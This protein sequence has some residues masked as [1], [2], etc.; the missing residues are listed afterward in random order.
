M[1][2]INP[3]RVAAK[4]NFS[5]TE[6]QDAQTGERVWFLQAMSMSG[7]LDAFVAGLVEQYPHEFQTKAMIAAGAPA[8]GGCYS[9]DQC[10]AVWKGFSDRIDAFLQM[11]AR[12][13]MQEGCAPDAASQFSFQDFTLYY[14]A[15]DQTAADFEGADAQGAAL[16]SAFKR[17][18]YS[19]LCE[20][21]ARIAKKDLPRLL[22][23]FC[24]ESHVNKLAPVYCPNLSALLDEAIK[25]HAER[26]KALLVQTVVTRTVFREL[27]FSCSEGVPVPFVG[28]SRFG[29]TKSVAGWCAAHPGRARLV[30]VPDSNREIDFIR[31]H[32]DAFGIAYTTTISAGAL[33]DKVESVLRNSGLMVVYDEAHFLIPV[34][35]SKATAPRRLNWVRSQVIDQGVPCAFFA[36]P[37]SYKQ[38]LDKYVTTTGYR[39]EQWLGRMAPPVIL[40]DV[41]PFEEIVAV[42]RKHFPELPEVLLGEIADRA[43]LSGGYLK[44][45]E[46][47][48][49]RARFLARERGHTVPTMEDVL[50]A[51]EA[52]MPT[53]PR[54]VSHVPEQEAAEPLPSRSTKPAAEPQEGS[55]GGISRRGTDTNTLIP[56][57]LLAK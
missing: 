21:C 7:G 4:F 57:S 52:M 20:N 1:S 43:I 35:Y 19:W 41:L 16:R 34:R 6:N 40:S 46:L 37:Q 29:K 44:S 47:T 14:V 31:A 49:R 13:R 50:D 36:T 18:N 23:D 42:A 51:I 15:P 9:K 25:N 45:V 5:R 26:E 48:G 8:V 3:E 55:R 24:Q 28:E 22:I 12:E 54:V 11:M 2:I 33:K 38:T 30:T 10:L 56:D 39:M 53:S 32:A 27:E 17:F